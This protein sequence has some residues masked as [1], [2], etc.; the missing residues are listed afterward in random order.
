M[1]L[2][3]ASP[4][5]VYKR[6][7]GKEGKNADHDDEAFQKTWEA[8]QSS[9]ESEGLSYKA[10]SVDQLLRWAFAV[11]ET[12]L[13]GGRPLRYE[14]NEGCPNRRLQLPEK[15]TEA[16][17]VILKADRILRPRL[18]HFIWGYYSSRPLCP[19]IAPGGAASCDRRTLPSGERLDCQA[20][21]LSPPGLS[22][23]RQGGVIASRTGRRRRS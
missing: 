10:C 23:G 4:G 21:I 1:F 11:R 14:A 17:F 6:T 20:C 13:I 22:P 12:S 3:R 16:A 7:C 18:K 2:D 5:P 15:L 19:I 9:Q 8:V